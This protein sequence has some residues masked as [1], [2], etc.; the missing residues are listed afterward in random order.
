MLAVKTRL[1]Q[2][3]GYGTVDQ[4]IFLL[5]ILRNC[6]HNF[7]SGVNDLALHCD[8][9]EL[10]KSHRVSYLPSLNKSAEPFEVIHFDV[11]G[12]A[13]VPSISRARYFVTFINEFTRMTCVSLL[14]KKNCVQH[15]STFTK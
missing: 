15:F 13:K 12:P 1:Q 4:D 10:A 8:T 11:W 7:F 9:C 2:L 5:V 3:Y 6:N 14:K